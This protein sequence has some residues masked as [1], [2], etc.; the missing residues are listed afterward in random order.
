V[1]NA[2][3]A[4]IAAALTGS[5]AADGQ[6]PVTG[7]SYFPNGT[8]GLP[9]I[10]F[11]TN[12][13]SG[14]YLAGSQLGF[15]IGGVSVVTFDTSRTGPGQNGS[16]IQQLNGAIL[17]PVGVIHDFAGGTAPAGWFL[18][19]G[20]AISRNGYP[21]L[22]NVIGTQ[23]GI[24][25]GVNTYNLPD[26]RGTFAAGVDNMGG[27]PANRI[28]PGG[29]GINGSVLAATGGG[30]TATTFISQA[31][32]PNVNFPV[33]GITL[34]AGA[35]APLLDPGGGN[36]VTTGGNDPFLY[37]VP[38]GTGGNQ[39]RQTPE[40]SFNTIAIANQGQAASGGSGTGAVAPNVPP[41]MMLNKIIF[42]GRV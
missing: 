41:T 32:L 7:Q 11:V 28:T 23:Y 18:C 35:A 19:F 12:K 36:F 1:V 31:N 30:E 3:F 9:G 42:A 21:E 15:S 14:L 40:T 13:T 39:L 8:V 2:N 37:T 24:G 33:S 16:L 25:D 29:S 17:Q 5:V 27:T 4:D 38:G 10:A 26:L 22:F 6:T 20:Q 34:N